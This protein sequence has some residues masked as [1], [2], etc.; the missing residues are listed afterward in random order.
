[1]DSHYLED[2]FQFFEEF[3]LELKCF[4]KIFSIRYQKSTLINFISL[5][6]FENVLWN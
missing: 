5:V 2:Y 6:D 4:M 1:M 3:V